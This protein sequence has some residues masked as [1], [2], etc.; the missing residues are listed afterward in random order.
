MAVSGVGSAANIVGGTAATTNSGSSINEA[1]D[2]FMKML[3]AQMKNQDPLN[4]MDNAEMTSQLAQLNMVSGINQL[5]ST[6]SGLAANQQSNQD[7]SAA[8]LLGHTVLVPG[9]HTAL[10]NGKANITMDLKQSADE[11]AVSIL[12]GQGH[13]VRS[14]TLGPQSQGMQTIQWDGQTDEG[15]QAANGNYTFKIDA[16]TAGQAVTANGLSYG[17]VQSV[18]LNGGLLKVN[19]DQVG[20][21]GISDVRQI[22]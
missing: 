10:S 2:R 19:V 9:N 8:G 6:L 5:N 3:I 20:D 15:T 14:L 18:S 16:V 11:V 21:V 22:F 4:P 13:V 1:Q 7:I 17:A 12:D